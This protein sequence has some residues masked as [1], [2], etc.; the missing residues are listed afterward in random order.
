MRKSRHWN[1]TCFCLLLGFTFSCHPK[2]YHISE[3]TEKLI[4]QKTK[5]DIETLTSNWFGGREAGSPSSKLTEDYIFLRFQELGLKANRQP[6]RFPGITDFPYLA[7]NLWA[8]LNNRADSTIVVTAHYDHLGDGKD[9]TYHLSHEKDKRGLHP[10]ADKNASG[11]AMLLELARQLQT[12]SK[13][14]YNYLFVALGAHEEGLYGSREMCKSK[15]LEDYRPIYSRVKLIVNL[16]M[17]GRLNPESRGLEFSY[18]QGQP[19]LKDL[20]SQAK[21]ESLNIQFDDEFRTENDYNVFCKA[22]FP[23]ISL[24][25]GVHQDRH[26]MSDTADKINYVGMDRIVNFILS[27]L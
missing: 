26:R 10:G 1:W 9:E 21:N 7:F 25:T 16:D 22:G 23:S 2:P 6:F 15:F 20:A 13:K 11:I 24:T 12:S 17:V 19:D 27:F 5:E 8:F 18:C 4:Q 3:N 14:Q